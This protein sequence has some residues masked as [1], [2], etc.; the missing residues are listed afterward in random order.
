MEIKM[1]KEFYVYK[2]QKEKDPFIQKLFPWMKDYEISTC[3]DGFVF[4]FNLTKSEWSGLLRFLKHT[5]NTKHLP[6]GADAYS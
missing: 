3:S 6:S 1:A 2:L 5:K 4:L